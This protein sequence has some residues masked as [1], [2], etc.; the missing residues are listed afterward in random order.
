MA[1]TKSTTA[2]LTG[3]LAALAATLAAAQSVSSAGVRLQAEQP[4]VRKTQRTDLGATM[5]QDLAQ[6]QARRSGLDDASRALD[7]LIRRP[8]PRGLTEAER[9]SWD[10]QT[11]WLTSVRHRYQQL[12]SSYAATER[13]IAAASPQAAPA[14]PGGAV[15]S[16]AVSGVS[17]ESSE[18]ARQSL[19]AEVS[20]LSAQLVALQ[21]E[22]VNESRRFQTLSNASKARH[23]TAMSIIQNMKA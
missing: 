4:R 21:T 23:D 14:V 15:I 22:I 2:L 12:S 10:E 16:G 18:P 3:V 19:S 5:K 17:A 9:K 8:A 20:Q 6:T 7:E 11:A 1:R 13:K